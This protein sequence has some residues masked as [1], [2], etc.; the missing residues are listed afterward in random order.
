LRAGDRARRRRRP[1]SDIGLGQTIPSSCCGSCARLPGSLAATPALRFPLDRLSEEQPDI[2]PN[3]LDSRGRLATSRSTNR[4]R[5]RP[6]S[7][8]T[9]TARP[10]LRPRLQGVDV[11][12]RSS[13]PHIQCALCR[14]AEP[15]Q[16][17]GCD[18]EPGHVAH[19]A[20]RCRRPRERDEPASTRRK[21]RCTGSL[22]RP[23]PSRKT[24]GAALRFA[25]RL[26]QP[27]Y[28]APEQPL[29][30]TPSRRRSTIWMNPA[31][32][33]GLGRAQLFG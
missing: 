27:D 7:T 14:L 29:R 5:R 8:P 10:Y 33:F 22:R 19:E 1:C 9:C 16:R 13:S 28:P 26:A 31:H 25:T 24:R 18:A 20:G 6:D 15:D 21:S 30:G 32:P 3:R 23:G 17:Y 12:L 4:A 11:R 2:Q